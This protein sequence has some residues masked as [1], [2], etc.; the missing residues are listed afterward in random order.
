MSSEIA[1]DLSRQTSD[2]IEKF[3]GRARS[4]SRRSDLA[5]LAIPA[6]AR[7]AERTAQEF[8]GRGEHVATGIDGSMD[9]DERLQ[10]ILFYA[11]ATAYSCP[12]TVG[13]RIAFDLESARRDSRL[14]ASAA[15]PLWAEDLSSVV[16]SEPEIDIKLKQS[17]ERIPNTIKKH[18]QHY[19]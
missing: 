7:G 6:D 15:V 3:E 2:L 13:S 11:N 8:F 12:F 18:R 10:M 16:S 5:R 17:M 4:F 14:G 19:M 9:F 1:E